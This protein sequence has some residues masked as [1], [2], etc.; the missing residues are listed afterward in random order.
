[1]CVDCHAPT[2]KKKLHQKKLK[3]RRP[4]IGPES[5]QPKGSTHNASLLESVQIPRLGSLGNAAE[6]GDDSFAAPGR[7]CCGGSS[8]FFVDVRY[9]YMYVCVYIYT[10]IY[11]YQCIYTYM[12]VYLFVDLFSWLFVY[13]CMI[14]FS[15][16]Y[17][18]Y[19]YAYMF[20]YLLCF[21]YV[22]FL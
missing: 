5:L 18:I 8:F 11:I 21:L 16:S 15:Y 22:C 19:I 20:I 17:V 6:R 3:S 7:G 2:P 1:M 9:I 14:L 10:Y 12:F 13:S 4:Q